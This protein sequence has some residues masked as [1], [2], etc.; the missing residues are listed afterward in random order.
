MANASETSEL[1]THLPHV[2]LPVLANA[3]AA[4]GPNALLQ[5]PFLSKITA[6]CKEMF[7][8]DVA[9]EP[10]RDPSEPTE[11][12]LCFNVSAQGNHSDILKRELEWHD[13]VEKLTG[14]RTGEYRLSIYPVE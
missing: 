6:L 1:T 10:L 5:D 3:S 8:S 14:D 13:R 11:S 4:C 9:L 7:D 2:P 12:W